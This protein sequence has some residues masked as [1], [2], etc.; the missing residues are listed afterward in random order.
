VNKIFFYPSS[1]EVETFVPKPK[2]AKYYLPEWYKKIRTAGKKME[3]YN[4]QMTNKSLKS[5]VPYLDALSSGYIQETWCDIYFK[6]NDGN[7]E[8]NY[9]S[10]P[11]I[12]GH[13]D[14]VSSKI[15]DSFYPLELEWRV[16]WIPKAKR[17][18]SILFTQPLN[19][20]DLPFVNADGIIDSDNFY[21][22]SISK[23]AFYLYKNFEGIIPAG[24]PMFQMIPIKRDQW[25]ANF[26][27]Y[28]QEEAYK[29][30]YLLNRSFSGVYK[31]IFHEKKTYL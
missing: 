29:R 26:E 25:K 23:Y 4:G 13:R 31:K 18:Y 7:F 16:P 3:F 21:H 15:N 12:I 10:N 5:C 22:S 24:T 27:K 30:E 28:D 6:W 20:N 9:S 1:K 8:Y 17:G 2:P 11:Q 14:R 19:R